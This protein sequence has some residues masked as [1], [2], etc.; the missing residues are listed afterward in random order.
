MKR[1]WEVILKNW[2]ETQANIGLTTT[3]NSDP[4][5]LIDQSNSSP[6]FRFNCLAIP[7][8]TVVRNE[9][10][11]E[12]DFANFVLSPIL[13]KPNNK[14]PPYIIYQQNDNYF[15]NKFKYNNQHIGK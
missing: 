9:S 12:V 14:H 3:I 13:T 1:K 8:G 7:V 11:F 4:S 15:T 6:T 5:G 10:L 2:R